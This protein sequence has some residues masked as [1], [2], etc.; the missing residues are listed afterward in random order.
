MNVNIGTLAA[1]PR[2]WCAPASRWTTT[3]WATR[4]ATATVDLSPVAAFSDSGSG[5]FP[6]PLA[7]FSPWRM[8]RFNL[9][10]HGSCGN[11]RQTRPGG[12]L[13]LISPQVWMISKGRSRGALFQQS[14]VSPPGRP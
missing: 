3:C 5:R 9:H 4:I 6:A 12:T 11:G 2:R 10:A 8:P 7:G 1:R 13:V 14:H